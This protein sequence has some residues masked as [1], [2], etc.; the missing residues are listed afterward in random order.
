M[1][2]TPTT[3]CRC[4]SSRWH[5]SSEANTGSSYAEC[6]RCGRIYYFQGG[7]VDKSMGLFISHA[8]GVGSWYTKSVASGFLSL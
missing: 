5:F 4:G 7:W 6:L 3:T 2:W 1:P 8:Q